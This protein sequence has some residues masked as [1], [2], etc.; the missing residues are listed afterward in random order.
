MRKYNFKILLI[1]VLIFRPAFSFENDKIDL[2]NFLINKYEVTIKEF[3]EYAARNNIKTKAELNGGGYEW[4]AG[5]VKRDNWFYFSPYGKKPDSDLE[6]A[7][8]INKFEAENYCKSINGRLPT[9]EEWSMAAYK[10]LIYSK[11]FSK[12]KIYKYPSGDKAEDM[13]SQGLLDYNKHIDVTKLP[14]GINGLV[15]MGGNVW[16]WIDD[17]NNNESLT[18]G[19][20]WWYGGRKTSKD[21]A[22]YKPSDFFAIYVGFR[23]VFDK[24]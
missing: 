21:G 6:P 9:F 15:A 13:N 19:A 4:G 5:W 2:G 1:F 23:C 10:Q 18:A 14:E 22:Q 20:S 8:H 16:E 11:K 24:S 3:R 12:G 7:V 17:Q